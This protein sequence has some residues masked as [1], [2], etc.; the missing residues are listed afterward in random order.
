MASPCNHII[1]IQDQMDKI[2]CFKRTLFS[3]S[4]LLFVFSSDLAAVQHG[5]RYVAMG[6]SFAA[7]IGIPEMLDRGCGRS[8]RNYA[9]IVADTLG[10]DLVDVTCSGA[11]IDHVVDESQLSAAGSMPPQIDALTE[12][13]KLVTVTVGGNSF[14]YSLRMFQEACKATS[15][16]ERSASLNTVCSTLA[17]VSS[18]DKAAVLDLIEDKLVDMI[19]RIQRRAPNA[20]VVLV[21]Y[22][23]IFPANAEPCG[24]RQ[25]IPS[26]KVEDFLIEARKFSMA[27]I[28]AAKRT[29]VSVIQL[30][31][32]SRDHH[33]CAD[34]PWVTGF[35]YNISKKI[36]PFHPN[37]HAMEAA[38]KMI[39]KALSEQDPRKEQNP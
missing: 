2:N 16:K 38:A 15:F 30:S 36:V 7:G 19:V 4:V 33:V 39:L 6:S 29:G 35:E 31:E 9:R 26:E 14:G 1:F 37:I 34:D 3:F 17:L 27:I 22:A 24:L 25:P 28:K 11:T 8:S 23:T 13:T 12:N 10:L 21:D 18:S 5:D 20:Q 32:A